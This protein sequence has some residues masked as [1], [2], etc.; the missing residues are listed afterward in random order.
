MGFGSKV[1]NEETTLT[2]HLKL[3]GSVT[4]RDNLAVPSI[5][6][7]GSVTIRGNLDVYEGSLSI[8]GSLDISGDLIITSDSKVNGSCDVRGSIFATYLKV[9]GSLN[10]ESMDGE[11][12]RLSNEITVKNDM[13]ASEA[14]VLRISQ[15]NRFKVGG[16]IEA[17][18]VTFIKTERFNLIKKVT[19]IL[20]L[21]KKQSSNLI[22]SDISI[23]AKKLF[24][25]GI[26]V[27]GD[28]DVEEV[29]YLE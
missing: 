12:F 6:V 20:R 3:H 7:N 2:E 24:L 29:I 9:N 21:A 15:E 10:A 8:N 4:S 19:S 17:P 26:E 1:F 11:E 25:K 18:E 14:I 23:K 28:I 22:I 16:I 27:E 5:K 13:I